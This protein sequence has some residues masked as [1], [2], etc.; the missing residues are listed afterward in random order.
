MEGNTEMLK[1]LV[2]GLVCL[3]AAI[4]SVTLGAPAAHAMQ[5]E[6]GGGSGCGDCS[7]GGGLHY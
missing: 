7:D 3:I 4:S 5:I 2:V 1:K 6:D